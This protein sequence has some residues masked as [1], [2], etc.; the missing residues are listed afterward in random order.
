M[1]VLQIIIGNEND[2]QQ[3]DAALCVASQIGYIIPKKDFADVLTE[4][5]LAPNTD[6]AAEL[7]GKLV[8]TLKSN[9]EPNREF[10]R[11]R[12]VLIETVIS[13]VEACP[14]YIEI[15]R[16]KEAEDALNKLKGTSS[17]LEKYKVFIEGEGMVP[18][19]APMHE[20]VDKAKR[21]IMV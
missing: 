9:I 17:R 21:L 11:L 2:Q 15:F 14:G 1:Q 8:D 6:T 19:S 4:N 3:L 16:K 20:V 13:I 12:R 18:E 5:N 7:V 10:P